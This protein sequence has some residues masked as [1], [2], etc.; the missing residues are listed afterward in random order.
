[1]EEQENLEGQEDKEDEECQE[2]AGGPEGKVKT[3]DQKVED[4]QEEPDD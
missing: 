1:M 2:D 4:D 3:S